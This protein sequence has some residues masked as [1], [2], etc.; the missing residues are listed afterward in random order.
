MV[1]RVATDVEE[2]ALVWRDAGRPIGFLK[3][4]T[5]PVDV[6]AVAVPGI[7]RLLAAPRDARLVL[8]F[9]GAPARDDRLV[10]AVAVVA[11]AVAGVVERTSDV[12]DGFFCN[13]E[14]G[15]LGFDTAEMDGFLR[16]C[17]VD[18]VGRSVD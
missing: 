13:D 10:L 16:N 18:G 7:A 9:V 4:P 6:R 15:T 5:L 11:A 3:T 8:A 1:L 2:G 17:S 14:A 12:L